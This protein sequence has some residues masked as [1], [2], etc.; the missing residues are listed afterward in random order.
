MNHQLL[1]DEV[2]VERLISVQ[3][4]NLL[5]CYMDGPDLYLG[6]ESQSRIDRWVQGTESMGLANILEKRPKKQNYS[7]IS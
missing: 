4:T 3:E 2:E 6:G 5:Y 1:D 7:I